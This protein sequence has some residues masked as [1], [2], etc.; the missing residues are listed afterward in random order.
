[1]T[2]SWSVETLVYGGRRYDDLL[3]RIRRD[4]ALVASMWDDA[5]SRPGELAVPGTWWTVAV[6]ADG[7]PAAWCAA[8]RED[9]GR[10]IKCHS[11]YERAG[12]RGRGLYAA[13][14][15]ARHRDV[16]RRAGVA[17]VTYLF[18]GPIALHE[19]DGWRRTGVAGVSALGHDWWELRRPAQLPPGHTST[20]DQA[21]V[22]I[23][24]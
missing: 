17:G 5:E 12:H 11:N 20:S 3:D 6:L 13:A 24:P 15:R 18:D 10:V 16:L 14:Y 4:A 9:D 2:H 19:A 7:T 21:D 1:M 22:G 23:A 8:V